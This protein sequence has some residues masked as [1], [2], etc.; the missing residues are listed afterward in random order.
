[1]F[2]LTNARRFS[3]LVLFA[4]LLCSATSAWAQKQTD[5]GAALTLP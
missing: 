2:R 1:M 4:A 3:G 5:G